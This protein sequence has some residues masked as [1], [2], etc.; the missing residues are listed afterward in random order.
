MQTS[1]M[2]PRWLILLLIAASV[3]VCS[4][5]RDD[6]ALSRLVVGQWQGGRHA[7]EYFADGTWSFL[8][9][10]GTTSGTW[11]IAEGR[12]VKSWAGGGSAVYD[13]VRLDATHWVLRGADGTIFTHERIVHR[14]RSP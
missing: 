9:E 3:A 5:S 12:F 4:A 7:E 13:I 10:V 8:P 1:R 6:D 14:D 11:R 2:Y